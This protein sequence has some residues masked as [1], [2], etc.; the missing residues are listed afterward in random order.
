VSALAPNTVVAY[1]VMALGATGLTLGDFFIKKSSMAE[2]SI[3][4]LLVFAW[5]LTV[6]GLVMLA[7]FQGGIRRHLYPRAPGKLFIRAGL[8]LVMSLMNISS[9]SLNPYAQHA[10]LF[11]LSPIFAL[12]IAVAFLGEE[13]TGHVIVVVLICLFGTW[14]ILDPG[15]GRISVTLLI[16]V[17]AALSNAATNVFVATNRSHA[18][19]IG[20]TFWAVNGVVVSVGVYWLVFERTLPGIEAQIWIQLSALF[21]V[22]GIVLAS[23]AM[24]MAGENIGRVTVMLY[25]QMPIALLLGWLAFGERPSIVAILGGVLIA[26]AGAS[27]PLMASREKQRKVA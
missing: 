20:F 3:A 16:A 24:Q 9:L 2:V 5:P 1:G 22:S 10:M 17:A 25:I 23:L 7:K 19:F 6:A 21:A 4:G 14:F 8:L 15:P 27:L 12:L 11:Q 13:L 26:L 18:T